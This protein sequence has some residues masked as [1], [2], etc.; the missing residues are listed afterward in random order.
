LQSSLCGALF[1]PEPWFAPV[2]GVG[3]GVG[4]GGGGGGQHFGLVRRA[5]C[6]FAP[7]ST[8][9]ELGLVAVALLSEVRV[10]LWPLAV[11]A[12][13]RQHALCRCL[14]S[15]SALLAS[16]GSIAPSVMLH[17]Q[18]GTKSNSLWLDGHLAK[19]AG[20]CW[21]SARKVRAAVAIRLSRSEP[22]CCAFEFHN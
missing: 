5:L 10:A 14:G 22:G 19:A 7:R 16:P 9:N 21:A 18:N 2:R 4:D 20:P 8:P 12:E 13:E 3:V 15:R 1:A 17:L 11:A 6:I